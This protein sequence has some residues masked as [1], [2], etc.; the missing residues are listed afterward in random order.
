MTLAE[1]VASLYLRRLADQQ[2][3]GLTL[4]REIHLP[5]HLREHPGET[6][7][8]TDLSIYTWDEAGRYYL[9]IFAGKANKPYVGPYVYK[10]PGDRQR[11]IDETVKSRRAV[12]EMKQK[13]MQERR[14]FVHNI[15]KG[16]IFSTSWGYDQT[17][18]D[19]YEVVEVKGKMVVVREVASKIIRE[20]R[21]SDLVMP[22]PGHYTGQAKVVKPNPSG[23][24]RV[25][26][27]YASKWDGKPEHQTPFGQ[28]H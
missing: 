14:D 2:H 16:E 24:F 25:D 11:R 7:E 13:Q 8:G 27:H 5:K 15:Q 4:P 10:N 23:G 17:N 21:G 6:P 9:I 26:D 28:G 12:I 18:V 22:V 19:F 20:D 3:V 1:R